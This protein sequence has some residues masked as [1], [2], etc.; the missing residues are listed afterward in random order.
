MIDEIE[1]GQKLELF[2]VVEM[3]KGE[4]G[5]FYRHF[6]SRESIKVLQH[7]MGSIVKGAKRIEKILIKAEK[8]GNNAKKTKN[9]G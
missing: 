8:D 6:D 7:L 3:L 4:T 2:V 5:D 9:K 1:S